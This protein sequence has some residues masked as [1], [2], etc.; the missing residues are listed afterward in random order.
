MPTSGYA[1]QWDKSLKSSCSWQ[2]SHVS[3]DFW[4]GSQN[5]EFLLW[6]SPNWLMASRLGVSVI[7]SCKSTQVYSQHGGNDLGFT[8]TNR[9]PNERLWYVIATCH[10]PIIIKSCFKPTQKNI[11][12]T[13]V[14]FF[15]QEHITE[16]K[17]WCENHQQSC[18]KTKIV[19]HILYQKWRR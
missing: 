13:C 19:F 16:L 17:L 1:V 4:E 9:S 12:D 11:R 3:L 5:N 14:V 18:T 15:R 2:V 6:I 10:P 8:A 7:Q